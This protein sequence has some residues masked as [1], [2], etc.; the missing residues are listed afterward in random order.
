MTTTSP[1]RWHAGTSAILL[2]A[3]G[4]AAYLVLASHAQATSACPRWTHD[5]SIAPETT[6][7]MIRTLGDRL[8]AMQ[9]RWTEKPADDLRELD[10]RALADIGIHAGQIASIE[11]ARHG[12]LASRWHLL[13]GGCRV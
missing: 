3:L 6:M 8:A 9:Q 7:P 4:S 2:V 10:A 5:L 13:E 12:P 1:I 11:A